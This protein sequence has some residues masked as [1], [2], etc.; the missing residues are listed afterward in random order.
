MELR[1]LIKLTF[2]YVLVY[3]NLVA[4]PP[5]RIYFILFALGETP[6]IEPKKFSGTPPK[7]NIFPWKPFSSILLLFLKILISFIYGLPDILGWC[8]WLG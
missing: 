5:Y 7:T 1:W 6:E 4:F 3:N 2:C 8:T